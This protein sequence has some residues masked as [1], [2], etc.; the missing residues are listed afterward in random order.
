MGESDEPKSV[1]STRSINT[2][3]FFILFGL[4][5]LFSIIII[6]LAA[7]ILGVIINRLDSTSTTTDS[8]NNGRPVSLAEQIKSDDLM[9]H[10]EQLQVI[11]DQSNGT[12]A[13]GTRGFDGTLDYITNQLQQNTDFV[14]RHDYF[15]ISNYLVQGTPQFQ[16]Q[17]NE[18]IDNYVYLTDFT[19]FVFS[20]GVNFDSFVPLVVIPNLGC[21]DTDWTNVSAAN[22]IALVKR[23]VCT[24]VEKS[25]L[26]EKYQVRGLLVYNDGTA[27]DRFQA[28][29]NVRTHSNA[30]IPAYFLSYNVGMRFVNA[31]SNSTTNVS[32][33]MKIDVSDAVTG[34]ICADTATGNG[35]KTIV[36]GAHSDG[37]LDGSGINDNGK[38]SIH[39]LI[40]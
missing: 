30:T 18:L 29:Q 14:I 27:P 2:K 5:V 37:V 21:Q 16:S 1:V 22:S 39:I 36:V 12:R 26:A 11:A 17:I 3:V 23:G 8:L 24:F 35:T 33:M 15:T 25:L 40:N 6:V 10:L 38:K 20:P 9:K 13:V 19:H 32:I 4:L 7:A 31:A 28:I 34:N